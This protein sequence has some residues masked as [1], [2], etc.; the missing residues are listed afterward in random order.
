ML[1]D[2]I[3]YRLPDV[4]AY[5]R[6]SSGSKTVSQSERMAQEAFN[7]VQGLLTQPELPAKTG[8]TWPQLRQQGRRGLAVVSLNAAY[9][10]ARQGQWA[11][12]LRWLVRGMLYN[13]L[14]LLD[15]RW[16]D[17]WV[18]RLQRKR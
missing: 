14:V 9:G 13:P 2:A 10:F 11:P 17:L 5:F 1:A 3:F 6:L 8:L 12:A 16:I 15:R 7:V 4:L 18:A